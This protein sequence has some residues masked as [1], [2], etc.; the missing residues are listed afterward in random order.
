MRLKSTIR[1]SAF[2]FLLSAFLLPGCATAPVSGQRLVDPAV[3]TT[4]A[5]E[6]TAVGA[7]I[8]LKAHPEQREAFV[9]AQKSLRA[10]LA[11]GQ[12][13]QEDLAAALKALPIKQLQG[14]QGAVIVSGAI[15]LLDTAGRQLA[16]RDQAH[17]WE[18]W[19]RPVGAGVLQGL[20]QVLTPQS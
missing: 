5:Y 10:L 20:D 1:I 7:P 19:V 6:A 9:M 11:V 18:N 3:L 16:A 4:I 17:V 8:Y 14:D 2:C 13:S 15:V 12:G